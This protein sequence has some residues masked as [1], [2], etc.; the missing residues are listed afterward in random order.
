FITVDGTA[1]AGTDYVFQDGQLTFAPGETS[2]TVTVTVLNDDIFEHPEAFT[3]QISNADRDGSPLG[4]SDDTGTGNIVDDGRP[5]VVQIGDAQATEG[6]ALL[7]TVSLS[8]ATSED[9]V[10]ALQ[11]GDPGT[12]TAGTDY[13]T[14]T[15]RYSTDGGTTWIDAANGNEATV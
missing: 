9:I 1:Q 8:G 7:F 5:P 11:A 14:T 2:K 6:D 13:E 10:L 3:V 12:A 4:I 15:F